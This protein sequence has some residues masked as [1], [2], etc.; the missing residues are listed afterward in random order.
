MNYIIC[1]LEQVAGSVRAS[2]GYDR[3]LHA[4]NKSDEKTAPKL[5]PRQIKISV[6]EIILI[7]VDIKDTRRLWRSDGIVRFIAEMSNQQTA[8]GRGELYPE[9]LPKGRN[10]DS[11]IYP[12]K[13]IHF[14][15]AEK[16]CSPTSSFGYPLDSQMNW[17]SVVLTVE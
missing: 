6:G 16:L 14:Y 4:S 9:R 12:K 5:S 13:S 3:F 11:V 8:A 2:I 7:Y 15:T 10:I 1:D 17:W